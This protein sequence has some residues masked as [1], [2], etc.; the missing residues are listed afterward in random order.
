MADS[1]PKNEK[2]RE[3]TCPHKEELLALSSVPKQLEDIAKKQNEIFDRLFVQNGGNKG[4]DCLAVQV[5][6]NTTARKRVETMKDDERRNK[7]RRRSFYAAIIGIF[8]TN[9]FMILHEFVF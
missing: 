5:Q 4:E 2:L 8:V 6:K 3:Q 9:V 7:W 1:E